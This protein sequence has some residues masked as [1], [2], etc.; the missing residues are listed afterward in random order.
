MTTFY[1]RVESFWVVH[2]PPTTWTSQH[3]I[4][5]LALFIPCAQVEGRNANEEVV[6]YHTY[7]TPKI[8]AANTIESLVGRVQVKQNR[9]GWVIIDRSGAFASTVLIDPDVAQEQ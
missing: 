8:I 4:H 2:C 1:G 5:V 3:E 6:E 7:L 9:N